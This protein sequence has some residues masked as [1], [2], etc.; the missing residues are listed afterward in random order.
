[1]G[2]RER[3]FGFTLVEL[4]VTISIISIMTIVMIP[5][6]RSF[7]KRNKVMSGAEQMKSAILE[8]R[9]FSMSPRFSDSNID[10]Y[11]IKIPNI[12]MANQI[13]YELGYLDN[14]GGWQVISS[15][16]L[17]SKVSIKYNNMPQTGD[18][19]M[20]G[21][22]VPDSMLILNMDSILYTYMNKSSWGDQIGNGS[23]TL[24][25]DEACTDGKKVSINSYTGMVSISNYDR[26]E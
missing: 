23:L 16:R 22:K 3:K 18:A 12:N 11:A 10:R 4:M 17:P 14:D 2:A 9:N 19:L 15:R 8:A 20:I 6:L 24:C 21:F 5:A 1:M 13:E 7:D 25:G 26:P